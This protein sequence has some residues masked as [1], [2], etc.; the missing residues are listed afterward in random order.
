MVRLTE[1]Y[2]LPSEYDETLQ[3]NRDLFSLREIVVNPDY[4]V[5][6]KNCE[7]LNNKSKFGP[8][9]KDL[10][11]ETPFTQLGISTGM[12]QKTINVVGS[13]NQLLEKF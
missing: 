5:F 9:V 4:V 8:L 2:E 11:Q 6:M 7:T 12:S 1:I 10:N 13:L 3:R